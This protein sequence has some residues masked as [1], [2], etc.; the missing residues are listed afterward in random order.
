MKWQPR[1]KVSDSDVSIPINNMFSVDH[2][3]AKGVV[4]RVRVLTSLHIAKLHRRPTVQCYWIRSE[5]HE[6]YFLPR[7][8]S[9][10]HKPWSDRTM[11]HSFLRRAFAEASQAQA[12]Y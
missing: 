4:L 5:G 10:E 9:L 3:L 2:K 6:S 8:S 1:K 7:S 12:T 11:V